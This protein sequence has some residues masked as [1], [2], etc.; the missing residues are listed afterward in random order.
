MD[1]LK[2]KA[3][4]SRICQLLVD[5]GSDALRAAFHAKHP[6]STLATVLSANKPVLK[7]IRYSVITSSQWNSLYPTSGAADS[8][9]FD[10]SLL[11]ILLRNICGLSSPK[12]VLNVTPPDGD[13]S[14]SADILRIKIFRNQVYDHITN[15]QLD[16]ATFDTLWQEISKPLVKLGVSQEDID[17]ARVAPLSPEEKFY[18]EKLKEWKELEDNFLSKLNDVERGVNNVTDETVETNSQTYEFAQSNLPEKI[19]GLCNKF[20][21]GTRQWFFDQLSRWFDDKQQSRV[22]ILTAGPGVGKSVLAAKVCE[23]Y[24]KREKLAAC[25]FCDF[26]NP[27]YSNPRR[28]VRSL[29]SQMCH[30]IKGFRDKLPE[31]L[32]CEH[33]CPDSLSDAFR[34]LLN[35]PLHALDRPEPVLIVIDAL[36]ESKTDIKNEFLELISEEFPELPPWVKILITSRPEL[37]V[38]NYLQHFNPVEI[39]PDDHPH[40]H[41]NDIKHYITHFLPDVA[42]D[43]LSSFILK[44][45][46]SFLYANY[47]VNELKEMDS[48]SPKLDCHTC[49]K[50]EES[51]PPSASVVT[52]RKN[53]KGKVINR[54]IEHSGKEENMLGEMESKGKTLPSSKSFDSLESSAISR[55]KERENEILSLRKQNELLQKKHKEILAELGE[56]TIKNTAKEN[57]EKKSKLFEQIFGSHI[58][59]AK[60]SSAPVRAMGDDKK[61]S[62]NIDE[63]SEAPLLSSSIV[64]EAAACE[65]PVLGATALT[66][67][68][69]HQAEIAEIAKNDIAGSGAEVGDQKS[70]ELTTVKSPNECQ[71][72]TH[73]TRSMSTKV[74]K[75]TTNSKRKY[76]AQS[77]NALPT[78]E[79][80]SCQSCEREDLSLSVQQD[81]SEEEYIS[82]SNVPP[83]SV[84]T[85]LYNNYKLLLMFIAQKLLSSDVNKLRN[86]ADQKFSITNPENATDILFQLDEKGLINASDLIQ[87]RD[88]FQS[89]T[90]IDLVYVIDAFLL[91]DYSL[92]R[93]NPVPK[94]KGE[95]RPQNRNT[96]TKYPYISNSGN[97][98]RYSLIGTTSGSQGNSS[99][100]QQSQQPSIQNFASTSPT[101]LPKSS[102]KN[103]LPAFDQQSNDPVLT[104]LSPTKMAE[105]AVADSPVAGKSLLKFLSSLFSSPIVLLQVSFHLQNCDTPL[106]LCT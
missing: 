57:E 97:T 65:Q 2:A 24:E 74:L 23:M 76:L 21:L 32:Q 49:S 22:M 28:I 78:S 103:H 37:Q 15:P 51:L 64:C 35:D 39:R 44:C 42:E 88:F 75:E 73:G 68:S 54:H 36:D 52:S 105:V 89:I 81:S 87:I 5:K 95:N 77:G 34:V 33:S 70:A 46:G 85:T 14:T 3:N 50:N 90:R 56:I 43:T 53:F 48:G 96:T 99:V 12:A 6:T 7:K 40:N 16:D 58:N 106:G 10:I 9:N 55:L 92:L 30:N 93:Q 38:R 18:I 71:S 104:R 11:T 91:G 8:K 72:T 25:H 61:S 31:I 86:W 100:F 47:L 94:R 4:F 26:K 102:N 66:Q 19:Q 13:T 41:R 60:D 101:H 79:V 67:R 59:V 45:D 63:N 98:S 27:D 20:Q 17:E 1:S 84:A 62:Q 82:L 29:F 69:N 80:T 83:F